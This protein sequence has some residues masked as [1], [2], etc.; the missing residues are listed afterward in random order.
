MAD[1]TRAAI[2][3]GSN[4]ATMT[5]ATM[6]AAATTM[7]GTITGTTRAGTGEDTGSPRWSTGTARLDTCQAGMV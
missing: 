7:A 1:G 4:G 5:E 2:L 6:T 3:I